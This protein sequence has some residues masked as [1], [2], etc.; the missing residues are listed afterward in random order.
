MRPDFSEFSYG[1]AV[2][3]ELTEF[4]KPSMR[5]APIFPSLR[6]EGAP[7][8]GYD[9]ELDVPGFPLFL[10][11]KVSECMTRSTAREAGWVPIPFYR[12]AIRCVG[13]LNQH[14]MLVDLEMQ[15]GNVF[16][17]TSGLSNKVDFDLSFRRRIVA[18]RSLWVPPSAIGQIRD[19]E[20]HCVVFS[21]LSPD[22]YFFSH[23]RKIIAFRLENLRE[24][25]LVDLHEH[26]MP[27]D[28]TLH[29]LD[30]TMRGLAERAESAYLGAESIEQNVPEKYDLLS[31]LAWMSAAVCDCALL[32]VQ[33]LAS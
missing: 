30:N 22:N 4:L 24:K 8:G 27:L 9:V 20:Q 16:Y 10:Q 6:Q 32:I 26:S 15:R 5:V 13:A 19:H 23:P 14:N 2:T 28:E 11:F 33:P 1:F 18:A 12:F 31:R 25:L 3:N 21:D 17:V 29:A 7:G